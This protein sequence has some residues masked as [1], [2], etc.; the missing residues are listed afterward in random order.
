MRDAARARTRARARASVSFIER[1]RSSRVPRG[2]LSLRQVGETGTSLSPTLPTCTGDMDVRK[3]KTR[4]FERARSLTC[5]AEAQ[6]EILS[7][8]SSDFGVRA[9]SFHPVDSANKFRSLSVKF[10]DIIPPRHIPNADIGIIREI[11]RGR[12]VTRDVIIST[13][14]FKTLLILFRFG[15][16]AFHPCS[17]PPLPLPFL[18]RC[19]T[20]GR[21]ATRNFKDC[22]I[23]SFSQG[24]HLRVGVGE[25]QLINCSILFT[26]S[27]SL[28][29]S[30]RRVDFTRDSIRP[31][32]FFPIE[33][34]ASCRLGIAKIGGA[35]SVSRELGSAVFGRK[36][37]SAADVAARR[38][39]SS[40]CNILPI[41]EAR[42]I[43]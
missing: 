6:I 29:L 25:L 20:S 1:S 36:G 2:N 31:L 41:T 34:E 16:D 13:F 37:G 11:P 19:G 23:A 28:S 27:L 10:L 26:C 39:Y 43:E 4:R 24:V 33:V 3:L 32:V 42:S 40:E 15:F 17:S 12:A 14:Y 22:T 18:A 21:L 38:G 5:T 30:I 35:S 8:P 7:V 9:V